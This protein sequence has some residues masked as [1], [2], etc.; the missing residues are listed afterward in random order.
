MLEKYKTFADNHFRQEMQQSK[1]KFN[2]RIYE[3]YLSCSLLDAGHKLIKKDSSKEPDICMN[4]ENDKIWIEA[5]CPTMG[6]VGNHNSVPKIVYE[7]HKDLDA[8]QMLCESNVTPSNEIDRQIKLRYTS[9]I[10]DKYKQV[11]RYISN[12]TITNDSS[13]V[14][15]VNSANIEHE[16]IDE[17]IPIMIKLCYGLGCLQH[18]DKYNVRTGKY[19]AHGDSYTCEF[20]VPKLLQQGQQEIIAG[21][22]LRDIYPY[23]SAI[24]FSYFRLGYNSDG[25]KFYLAHNPFAKKPLLKGVF[26]LPLTEFWLENIRHNDSLNEIL[27][28][29]LKVRHR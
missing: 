14:I 16:P 22:F 3:M 8:T 13:V 6:E 24:L 27:R 9:A 1:E 17:D 23:I 11:T 7:K 4:N 5:V 28:A 25:S 15:A 18:I 2:Q 10:Y 19:E 26:N 29:H 20:V 21:I 12:S